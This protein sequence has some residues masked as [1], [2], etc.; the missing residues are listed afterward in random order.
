MFYEAIAAVISHRYIM[1]HLKSW[2]KLALPTSHHI[3]LKPRVPGVIGII[4][5]SEPTWTSFSRM[6]GLR[7]KIS[8]VRS[9]SETS[10]KPYI[11]SCFLKTAP[12]KMEKFGTWTFWGQH[13]AGPP[14]WALQVVSV[15]SQSLWVTSL[16]EARFTESEVKLASV[17]GEN[18]S[19]IVR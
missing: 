5:P 18:Y 9:R 11:Q 15:S 16:Q 1:I 2:R 8:M 13:R 6:D 14:S 17:A 10:H 19:P 12:N 4:P 7:Q 3:P